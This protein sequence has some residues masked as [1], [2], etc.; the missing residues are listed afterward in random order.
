MLTK[1][2]TDYFISLSE[3]KT[4]LR[5]DTTEEDAY[6]MQLIKNAVEYTENFINKDIAVTSNVLVLKN[7]CGQ[8]VEIN[9]GNFQSLTSVKDSLNVTLTTSD[10]LVY[11]SSFEFDIDSTVSTQ[12]ITVNFVTGYTALTLPGTIRQYIMIKIADFYDVERSSYNFSGI[13]KQHLEDNLI[14]F[15]QAKKVKYIDY[16]NDLT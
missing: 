4:H 15:Y 9:E 11:D 6:I 12:D 1:T 7:F 8:E 2:K 10:L 3:A 5:V 16:N 14:A 13:N